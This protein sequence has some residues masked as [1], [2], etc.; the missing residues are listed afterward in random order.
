MEIQQHS[1]I[2]H[3]LNEW[4]QSIHNSAGSRTITPDTQLIP[5]L[6]QNVDYDEE[7]IENEEIIGNKLNQLNIDRNPNLINQHHDKLKLML[8]I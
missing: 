8:Y 1:G 6:Q 4:L 2:H 7:A 3:T 5:I